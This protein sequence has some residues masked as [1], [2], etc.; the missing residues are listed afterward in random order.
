M[1]S[2]LVLVHYEVEV[3]GFLLLFIRFNCDQNQSSYFWD[4]SFEK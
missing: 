2:K 1:C 3:V 4:S